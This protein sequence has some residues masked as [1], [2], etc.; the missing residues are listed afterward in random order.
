MFRSIAAAS[1]FATIILPAFAMVGG[2]PTADGVATR[3][4]VLIVGSR[5]TSCTATAIARDLL[6][7]AAH[8][9]LPGAIYKLVE[10]DAAHH[11][12]LRDIVRVE[13]HPQFD[14]NSLFAHRATAD[15]AL[16]KLA[17]P[18][19]AHFVPA[20][21]GKTRTIAPGDPFIVAGYGV[22][23]RDD[24]RT[25]GTLRTV[26]LVATG[27]PGSL[28]LRLVDPATQ[29]QRPGLSACTG[30]SGAPVLAETNGRLAVIGV[31]SWSTGPNMTAGCGGLTGITP[32]ARYRDWLVETAYKLESP[33][34]P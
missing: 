20:Q 22:T 28:Q 2:A 24:G 8:C 21:L 10:F 11:A 25:G 27:K 9:A 7:T 17:E 5:G 29:G 4:V 34:S 32:L 19:P 31:V 3:Q 1:C 18:L 16:M 33:V 12:T 26:R 15:V 30:D 6:L 13:Q 23:V 14:L